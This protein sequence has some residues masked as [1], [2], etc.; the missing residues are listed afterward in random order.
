MS[1]TCSTCGE[2]HDDIPLSFAAD[3]PDNYANLSAEDREERALI[4]SDQCILDESEFYVRG[5]LKIPLIDSDS[6]FLW[7]VWAS[8]LAEDFAEIADTWETEGREYSTGPYK[9]RLA[10][11]LRQYSPTTANLKLTVKIQPVG[12]RPLFF[13]D[14]VDHPLAIAQRDGMT[15]ENAHRLAGAVLHG[16]TL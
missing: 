8:L 12:E 16:E 7:G 9:G 14:E 4:S 2:D 10:N 6:P 1:W 13:V 15:L 3:F 11:Q 5:L